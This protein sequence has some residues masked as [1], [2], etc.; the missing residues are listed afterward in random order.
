MNESLKRLKL[1]GTTPNVMA[2]IFLTAL[3]K[4]VALNIVLSQPTS[5]NATNYNTFF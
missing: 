4:V 2:L 1:P 3:L 5:L